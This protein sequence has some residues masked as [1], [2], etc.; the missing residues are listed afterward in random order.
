M[1][2]IGLASSSNYQQL[3][4]HAHIERVRERERKRAAAVLL[5]RREAVADLRFS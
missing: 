3:H 5:F 2:V 4:T 1:N